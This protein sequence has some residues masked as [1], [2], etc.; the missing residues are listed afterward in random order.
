MGNAV[1][2]HGGSGQNLG[3]T[4]FDEGYEA[5]DCGK[6]GTVY[7]KFIVTDNSDEPTVIDEIRLDI[8]AP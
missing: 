6:V 4:E 1:L 2:S 7:L 8:I 3:R 5:D